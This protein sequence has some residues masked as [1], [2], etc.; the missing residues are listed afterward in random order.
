ME[1]DHGGRIE[2]FNL[3]A[4]GARPV[5]ADGQDQTRETPAHGST[6]FGRGL[7]HG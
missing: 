2:L 1:A 4:D 3:E 5:R 6:K 7:I